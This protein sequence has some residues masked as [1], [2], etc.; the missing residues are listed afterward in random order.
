M[1]PTKSTIRELFDSPRVYIIPNYQRAYVWNHFDQWEPLWLDVVNI[2]DALMTSALSPGSVSLKP[3]FLGATVLKEVTRPGDDVRSYRVVDG[4]QRLTT[5]QLLLTAVGNSFKE[6]AELSPLLDTVHNF[7]LNWKSGKLYDAEPDKIKP[8]GGDFLHF[9]E[10]VKAGRDGTPVPHIDGLIGDCY[11]YYSGKVSGWLA[12]LGSSRGT[13]DER[14]R[15]LLAAISDQLQVVSIWLEGENEAAIF[16]ALNARGE[17][18]SEWEKVKNLILAKAGD[19]GVDQDQLYANYLQEFDYSSWREPA[20]GGRRI[21]DVFLD[22]WLESKVKEAVDTRRVYRDFRIELDKPENSSN[23]EAWCAELNR[24]GRRFLELEKSYLGD[25][26]VESVFHTRRRLLSVGALWP[27]LL[28]LS[29]IE[30]S[31]SDLNRCLRAVDSFICRRAILNRRA[32]SFPGIALGLLKALPQDPTGET[33]YSKAVIDHLTAYRSTSTYWPDDAEVRQAVIS[34]PIGARN[35]V[36]QTLEKALMRGKLPGNPVMQVGLPIE[37]LMPQ[38]HSNLDDWPLPEDAGEDAVA[39]RQN[40]VQ[41]LGN[42]TLVNNRLNS[43]MSNGPWAQKRVALQEHDNL[44]INK[45]L[46]SHA[47]TEHWDEEQIRLRGERLANYILKIWPH[48]HAVTG[49]IERV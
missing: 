9:Q 14:A 10:I 44:F 22:Y 35:L 3:H 46:L 1:Q 29:R 2:T 21:S 5:I 18:L 26:D 4:Q 7:T 43:S 20:G 40:T 12:E 48:G 6:H 8:L 34:R 15:F 16:E 41:R 39:V 37:H 38:D 23:L 25:S 49:E 17:P 45:E 33:P 27:F 19:T 42:L 30:M 31:A 13:I 28:E 11:R 24:D 36:I 32:N 47:P